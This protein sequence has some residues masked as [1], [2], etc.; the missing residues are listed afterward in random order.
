MIETISEIT[1]IKKV[2]TDRS[3]PACDP[4]SFFEVHQEDSEFESVY[5]HLTSLREILKRFSQGDLDVNINLRGTFAGYLKNL[6]ANLRHL[7]WQ[8]EQV[9]KG[10]FTQR[11]D[12]MGEF[13][14]AFNSMVAQLEYSLNELKEREADERIRMMFDTTPLGC[15][16][17]DEDMNMHDCNM[18]VV[19]MFGLESKQK[20]LELHLFDDLTPVFQPDGHRSCELGEQY[21]KKAV[22]TGRLTFEWLH[23]NLPGEPIPTEVTLV[24]VRLRDQPVILAYTRDLRELKKTQSELE[25]ERLLL[26]EILQSSP[27]CFSIIVDGIVHFVTPFMREFFGI[28]EG[29]N[30]MDFVFDDDS[31]EM[32]LAELYEKKLV[33]WRS[34]TMKTKGGLRKEMLANLFMTDY[35]DK[36]GVM[37]WLVDVTQIRAVEEDLKKA[38][39]TA[40]YLAKVKTEFLANMSHEIRTPMNAILGM[41]HIIRQTELNGTQVNYLHTMEQSANLLLHIINDI[42]DFSKIEAGKML[43]DPTFFSLRV[44]IKEAFSMI[45]DSIEKKN[46]GYILNIAPDIPSTVFGDSI[47]LKQILINLLG[48]AIKFTSEG[49]VGLE[50]RLGQ[51][52]EDCSNKHVVILFS[53]SDSG[54]GISDDEIDRLFSP[55]VQS[56]T[57]TTRK[58]GGT[59]LGLAICKNLVEMMGG[60][61]WCKSHKN[62][63]TTFFFT[64]NF[65]LPE[66]ESQVDDIEQNQ[67][68][69]KKLVSSL[70]Y[71]EKRKT[72]FKEPVDIVIPEHLYGLS[73]LL[74]EDNKINQLVAK[75]IL[76]RKGFEIDIAGNGEEA[77]AMV[78]QKPY[79]L[80]LMDIQMPEM[81]GFQAVEVIRQNP[82][83]TD[84]PII[85]MTAHAMEGYREQCIAAGMNDYTTKP[86]IPEKLYE[87]IVQWGKPT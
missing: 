51:R 45:Q 38:R 30:L 82:L 27:V 67:T 7:T 73:I 69:E 61:I 55:F 26:R 52:V 44:T 76:K 36:K 10:D 53:V 72:D 74:A 78:R 87:L 20:F 25:R 62:Q 15:I 28:D 75:E 2:L 33:H 70:P 46:L 66:L 23:Q 68:A 57:S 8:V 54:I 9:A 84:L 77:V 58:Y 40:E 65:E 63:G 24:R 34:V 64:I 32:M 31:K 12:F 6:Q 11:V 17:T 85:A 83:Y 43:L 41:I 1:L 21:I 56:D 5:S 81:D 60:T 14:V 47:R 39:D 80:V 22:E 49:T 71:E 13:S 29:E 35:N 79:G 48:N 86:I 3:I 18:E 42:L 19:K 4:P 37:V 16:F 59:G 50:V